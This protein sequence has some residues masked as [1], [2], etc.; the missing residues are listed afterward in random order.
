MDS[1]LIYNNCCQIDE[2]EDSMSLLLN[3]AGQPDFMYTS[4]HCLDLKSL[5]LLSES[6]Q[7]I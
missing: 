7:S 6:I 5:R 4:A 3:S 2:G 1:H